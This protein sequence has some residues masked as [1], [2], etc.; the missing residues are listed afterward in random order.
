MRM[1]AIWAI[2][3]LA[4]LGWTHRGWTHHV[5]SAILGS[6]AAGSTTGA[7][8]WLVDESDH[9][10]LAGTAGPRPA[11]GAAC[12]GSSKPRGFVMNPEFVSLGIH[13]SFYDCQLR[14]V[15]GHVH[16]WCVM[17]GTGGAMAGHV[18]YTANVGTCEKGGAGEPVLGVVHPAPE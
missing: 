4:V 15:N 10:L 5:Q 13:F 3:F 1:L 16:H 11:S 9:G 2:I 18:E 17:G 6:G 14:L 7:A 8:A 12:S